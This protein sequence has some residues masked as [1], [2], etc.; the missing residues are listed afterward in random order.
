MCV[1][2]LFYLGYTDIFF[3]KL[4]QISSKPKIIPTYFWGLV[5]EFF[6]QTKLSSSSNIFCYSSAIFHLLVRKY[7]CICITNPKINERNKLEEAA[8]IYY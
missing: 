6:N 3:R 7:I 2:A 1:V 4:Q 5:V 8:A